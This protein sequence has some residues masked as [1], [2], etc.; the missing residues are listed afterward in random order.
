MT[1]TLEEMDTILRGLLG[2]PRW[3]PG[4]GAH[5]QAAPADALEKVEPL[6]KSFLGNTLHLLGQLTD[7]D[8]SRFLM[9]RLNASVP[10][11]HAF[12]RLT[13]KTLKSVLALLRSGE[14]ALALQ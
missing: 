2:A 8:M 10:F 4:R 14:P 7:P 6:A 9:A 3:P 11:F 5:V 12:E 13:R 1:F